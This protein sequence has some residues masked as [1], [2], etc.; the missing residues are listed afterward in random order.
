MADQ[1]MRPRGLPEPSQHVAGLQGCRSLHSL[2]ARCFP[3]ALSV[4]DSQTSMF[5]SPRDLVKTDLDPITL[6]GSPS[7]CVSNK[8]PG[9]TPAASS[10]NPAVNHQVYNLHSCT[11][12]PCQITAQ[13]QQSR[14]F[15]LGLLTQ[16]PGQ[17]VS[18]NLVKSP[19]ALGPGVP[20]ELEKA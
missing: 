16:S 13:K 18:Q 3:G 6:R 2:C 14:Y 17:P 15:T 5:E 12:Q 7:F 1:E 10:L 11:W 4:S 19:S 9:D 20:G 8:F